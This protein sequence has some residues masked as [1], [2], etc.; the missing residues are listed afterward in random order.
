MGLFEFIQRFALVF[1]QLMLE[2][3]PSLLLGLSIAGLL[4]V[5]MPKGWIGRGLGKPG[6]AS[7]FRAVLFGVPMPLCSCGVVPTAIGLKNDGAS[8]GAATGFLIST[9]QTGVDSILVSAAFLGWPFALFKV[10]AAFVTGLVGGSV[11]DALE[12][13]PSDRSTVKMPMSM[14][15]EQLWWRR[16]VEAFRYAVFDLL[17]MID[18]WLLVGL[19]ASVL[20]TLLIPGGSLQQVDW[21][22]GT[23]GMFLML[24]LSMPLYVCT[25]SSVPIAASL[26]AAGMPMGAALVFLMAGPA[27]N[28]ATLGAVY[29]G[30][31]GRV[32]TVYLLTVAL[33]SMAFGLVFEGLLGDVADLS[34]GHAHGTDWLALIS[35]V[36]LSILLLALLARRVVRRFRRS[37]PRASACCGGAGE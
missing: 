33:M 37:E 35:A 9:P 7:V 10:A 22:Q 11:V 18:L 4:H 6:I 32:L 15:G 16:F 14:V 31:G 8:R 2:L 21:V 19:L 36:V 20:I 30:L 1:W 23:G 13:E 34:V 24:A 28:V 27:T 17:A 5:F 26:I 3:A 12:R 25:T 29:R